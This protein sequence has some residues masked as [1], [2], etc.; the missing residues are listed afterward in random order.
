MAPFV[1][2]RPA[3]GSLLHAPD[4]VWPL[5]PPPAILSNKH[6]FLSVQQANPS[7]LSAAAWKEH[8]PSTFQLANT[9]V[10][11]ASANASLEASADILFLKDSLLHFSSYWFHFIAFFSTGNYLPSYK[12]F[13]YI[14]I[15][16]RWRFHENQG[17]CIFFVALQS[18]LGEFPDS[19]WLR[20]HAF[21]SLP[22]G[23]FDPW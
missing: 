6:G 11:D 8:S 1:W 16:H 21:P 12:N 19:E 9:S 4:L 7:V 2:E 15:T 14:S 10:S 23:Q 22:W 3:D 5:W 13:I 20:L 17:L 18:A